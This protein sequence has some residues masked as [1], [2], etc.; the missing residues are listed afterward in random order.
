MSSL[1]EIL[2]PIL[3]SLDP[4]FAHNSV[5]SSLKVI[6]SLPYASDLV[7]SYYRY[8]SSRL[9]QNLWG[10]DFPNPI[11][12]AAGFDKNARLCRAMESFGFGFLELG[13]VTHRKSNGNPKPR[14]FR[15][16]EDKALINRMG[17]NNEGPYQFIKNYHQEK[18]S[19]PRIINIAK[20]NDNTIV[21]DEAVK[22]MLDC[23]RLIGSCSD[24]VVF[25]LSCPNTE[26]GRTFEDPTAVGS[27]IDAI[28]IL[29]EEE[30]FKHPVLLKFSND[31]SVG[32]LTELAGISLEKGVGGFVLG[33][34]SVSRTGLKEDQSSLESIGRGGL[35]GSPI[36]DRA[37]E[38]VSAL[39][40]FSNGR[41]PIIA[42][43]GVGSPD[44]A[45]EMM[46]HGASL[47]EIY[48]ALVYEGPSVVKR[49]LEGL[50]IEL[51][52]KRVISIQDIVGSSIQ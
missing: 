44:Q 36:Y 19:I 9:A 25:N 41:V 21:G 17:L 24:I 28:M 38:R 30:A 14:L 46:R 52:R 22:D 39:Y 4:E 18:V 12:L 29:R 26:D 35:S 6:Q 33:N 32:L 34:T 10:F 48:T 23:Y 20:T 2:K 27:L 31:I 43:G 42:V 45:L 50:D 13:S 49:I 7:R 8:P 3:F 40:K 47:V 5:H 15:L 11:G 16:T 51:L 37:L 1:Y